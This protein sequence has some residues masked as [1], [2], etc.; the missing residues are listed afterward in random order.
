MAE[1]AQIASW[2]EAYL[3]ELGQSDRC[4]FYSKRTFLKGVVA[5]HPEL[6]MEISPR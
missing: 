6:T 4:D 1:T 2:L 3:R 5:A